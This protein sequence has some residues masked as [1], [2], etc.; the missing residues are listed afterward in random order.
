MNKP[1]LATIGRNLQ[2][3]RIAKGLSLSQLATNA[4]I[5]KSNLS[6]I[7]Q[8]GGNPTLDTIWR[9]ASQLDVPFGNLIASTE[10]ALGDES[11]QVKLL[12]QGTGHP[13]VDAYWMSCAAYTERVSE[14]HTPG[15]TELITVI[16]GQLEVGSVEN[17]KLLRAGESHTFPADIPHIYRTAELWAT[18]LVTVIYAKKETVHD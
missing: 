16:S 14:A 18:F 5:A 10:V 9:L 4:G 15:T 1:I 3:L 13:N 11:V 2:S 6:R 8:G 12:D 17:I 7:E